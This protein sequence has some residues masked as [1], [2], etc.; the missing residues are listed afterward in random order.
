MFSGQGFHAIDSRRLYFNAQT[1]ALAKTVEMHKQPI[2]SVIIPVFDRASVLV[3]A[4]KSILEQSFQEF[5]IIVVDDGS[6][7]R[8]AAAVLGIA[9][10]EPRIRCLRHKANRGA[11]AARNTGI[12]AAFGEWIAFCDS[13]DTWLPHSLDVRMAAAGSRNAQVVHAGGFVLRIEEAER[14][15]LEV[16]ALAGNVY[17]QLLRRP[18]PMFQSLLVRAKALRAIGGLDEA[19]VGYQEWDTAIRLARHFEFAFVPEPTFVYDCRRSD[20]ISKDL[21]RGARGYEYILKK[22]LRNIAIWAG[23]RAVSEHYFRLSSE[24]KAAGDESAFRRCR[25][26]SHLWWP[27][28]S[29]LLRDLRAVTVSLSNCAL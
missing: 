22:H 16:P 13:D 2:I 18:G 28:P 14:E 3:N 8:T 23:P 9:Q 27:N 5:E 26:L 11:Q 24:Y 21:L 6:R 19:I 10:T 17:R 7:D 20:T 15:T 4:I 25:G 12:R 1:G 29:A